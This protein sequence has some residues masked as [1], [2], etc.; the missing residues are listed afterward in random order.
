MHCRVFK[1]CFRCWPSSHKGAEVPP[2]PTTPP[3]PAEPDPEPE[4]Q[5]NPVPTYSSRKDNQLIPTRVWEAHKQGYTGVGVKIGLLD[6]AAVAGYAPLE[7]KTAFYK[8]YA[9]D[10]VDLPNSEGTGH[11]PTIGAVIVGG[12]TE[13]YKG[14]VAPDA[15]L[16]WGRVCR[17]NKCGN[18]LIS[19]AIKEMTEMGVRL[20]NLSLGGP[21]DAAKAESWGCWAMPDVLSTDSLIVAATGNDG[22][23]QASTPAAIP[24]YYSEYS[25]NFIAAANAAVNADG[26]VTD[27]DPTSH[28]CGLAANWCLT[29]PGYVLT[30]SVPGTSFEGK[31]GSNGTS[32]STGITTGVAALV[33]E[34]YPWMSASN[35]QQTIL[36]T[37]ADLGAAG[38]DNKFGWGLINAGKGV[39]G[40]GQFTAEFIAAT[41]TGSDSVFA[42]E[43]TGEGSLIVDGLGHLTLSANNTDTVGTNVIGG[44]FALT[45]SLASD[46]TVQAGTFQSFGGKITR[47]YTHRPGR[48]DHRHPGGHRSGCVRYCLT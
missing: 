40:P 27:L 15:S 36:T 24:Q 2:P 13:S 32:G 5:P 41:S 22:T 12:E 21:G 33:W 17:N 46:L 37:A 9:R 35:V 28:W 31:A 14:G 11:G 1:L 47:N 48:R 20:F 29:A 38:V 39:N 44:T 26:T 19:E 34:A 25:N 18:S 23:T 16:Y 7:G 30:G 6:S 45:G 10:D 4:P 3:P 43:I 8:D 42:N